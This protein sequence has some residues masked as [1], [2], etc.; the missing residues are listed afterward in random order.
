MEDCSC[1]KGARIIT[2]ALLCTFNRENIGKS[3]RSTQQH[4]YIS[5]RTRILGITRWSSKWS[6][7]VGI[8]TYLCIIYFTVINTLVL[9]IILLRFSAHVPESECMPLLEYRC[10]EVNC[11]IYNIGVSAFSIILQNVFF[12]ATGACATKRD[13]TV[14]V[15][16]VNL[17]VIE[18]AGTLGYKSST[19]TFMPRA[20]KFIS[21]TS[22]W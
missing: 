20:L 12:P 14:W 19:Y 11:I 4:G 17:Y 2:Y 9:Y 5:T 16:F 15:P 18:P 22:F 8:E 1:Q 10:M 3:L 13:Y 21:Y 7:I 6:S